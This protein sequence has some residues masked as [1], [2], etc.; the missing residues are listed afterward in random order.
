MTR[1]ASTSTVAIHDEYDIVHVRH[2]A[3][4]AASTAGF[5]LVQQTKLVTAAS[6]LARNALVYGGGGQAEIVVENLGSNPTVRMTFTD[7]GPGIPDIDAAMADGFT[8]GSGLGLGLGGAKRLAD[9]FRIESEPGRGT[10]VEIS[11]SVRRIAG[12]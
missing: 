8:T 3:R 6:E 7:K 4:E 9:H 10:M 1:A 12:P 11:M 5:S 2:A